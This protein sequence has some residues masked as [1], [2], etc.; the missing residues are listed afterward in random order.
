MDTSKIADPVL[1]ASLE[2]I[3]DMLKEQA[4][5]AAA[6]TLREPPAN[7]NQPDFFV[8]GLY[9]VAVKDTF[10]VM[11][12]AVFRLSKSQTRKG[13][14]IRHVRDDQVLEIASDARGMATIYDYDIVLFMISHLAD[15][16]RLWR[17]GRGAKPG[18]SF[19]P[20]SA[21]IFKFCRM[22]PGG[23]NYA[24]LEQALDRLKGTTLKFIRK[25]QAR[26]RS[27][28]IGLIGGYEIISYT[29]KDRIGTVEIDIPEWIYDAVTTHLKPEV[30][31]VHRDYFLI[32]KGLG[33]F[34]YRLAR[35]AAGMGEATYSVRSIHQRT[36]S[37]RELRKFA[38]DLRQLVAA[39]DLPEYELALIEGKD[40]IL[41]RMA[42]RG[43]LAAEPAPA[44][45]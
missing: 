23:D 33:R 39:N 44:V 11:D 6:T 29:A 24:R 30:L 27:K 17:D 12:V 1:R 9:D 15:Q 25:D 42:R 22:D 4:E 26:S 19:R 36:G 5:E 3:G 31:T 43:L 40:D 45:A 37:T 10:S 14:I 32:E 34:I 7:D 8:P 13:E 21:E 38:F 41:L 18:R 16:T 20:H 28:A 35:K 2:H